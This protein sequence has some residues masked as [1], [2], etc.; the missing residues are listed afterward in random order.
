M[1]LLSF[2]NLY[3]KKVSFFYSI[4]Q[5]WLQMGK[6]C[7][8]FDLAKLVKKDQNNYANREKAETKLERERER[9]EER[10]KSTTHMLASW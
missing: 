1:F 5:N 8:I 7:E 2:L 4:L 9:K 10:V 3:V 6:H